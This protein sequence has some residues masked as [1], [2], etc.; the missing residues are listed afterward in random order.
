MEEVADERLAP[1]DRG[2]RSRAAAAVVRLA[3]GPASARAAA[4]LPA[5]RSAGG[6]APGRAV[7]RSAVR[8]RDRAALDRSHQPEPVRLH[9]RHARRHAV[10]RREPGGGRRRFRS[11]CLSARSSSLSSRSSCRSAFQI[12]RDSPTSSVVPH[13]ARRWNTASTAPSAS[14]RAASGQP[15]FGPM[16]LMR[17]DLRGSRRW[18]WV[19]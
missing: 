18:R 2:L 12:C 16:T 5:D 7:G 4:N 17:G 14:M 8:R 1:D 6:S 13:G 9:A 19:R 11:A 3:R 10:P 15:V